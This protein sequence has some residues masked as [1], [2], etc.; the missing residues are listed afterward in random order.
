[1]QQRKWRITDGSG[2]P[3]EAAADPSKHLEQTELTEK[4]AEMIHQL[5]QKQRQIIL[6]YYNQDL[7]MKQI[8]EVLEVTESRV[9]QLHASA[10]F[11]LSVRLSRWNESGK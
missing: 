6:L 5:P 1:M 7:T 2:R 9:S 10:L 3:R 11:K 8:A 4:L